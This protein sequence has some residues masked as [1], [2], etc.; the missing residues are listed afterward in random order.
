MYFLTLD[1][2]NYL[3]GW[4]RVYDTVDDPPENM[5]ALETLDEKMLADTSMMAYRWDGEKLVLDEERLAR[6][7]EDE[8]NLAAA[9]T[10]EE[11]NR[12]DIDFLLIMG[13]Y[14]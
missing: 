13:G 12:A 4:S 3:T 9:P 8:E 1:E 11:R 10:L 2:D 7:K 6:I 5:P 14:E